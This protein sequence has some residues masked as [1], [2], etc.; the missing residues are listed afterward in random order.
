[1]TK[2]TAKIWEGIFGAIGGYAITC[3]LVGLWKLYG[4]TDIS[5]G[6]YLFVWASG[7]F[8][9][10]AFGLIVLFNWF[11]KLRELDPGGISFQTSLAIAWS[12]W[13]Y[14]HVG[15]RVMDS[16]LPLA[17]VA[18]IF[19]IQGRS[20]KRGTIHLTAFLLTYGGALLVM[21]ILNKPVHGANLAF[22]FLTA[23]GIHHFCWVQRRAKQK[24]RQQVQALVRAALPGPIAEKVLQGESITPEAYSMTLVSVDIAGFTK[25][26]EG[27]QPAVVFRTL[28]RLHARFDA[29]V[30]EN[31]GFRLKVNGD[32]YICFFGPW[33]TM[34]PAQCVAAAT[35]SFEAMN[36]ALKEV[37]EEGLFKGC[38]LRAGCAIGEVVG[39]QIG[40]MLAFDILG[41][42]VN[43]MA[44]VEAAGESGK[45]NATE[46][47]ASYLAGDERFRLEEPRKVSVK[48]FSQQVEMVFIRLVEES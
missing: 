33:S 48:G 28:N 35:I 8:C 5:D 21:D 46:T 19:S 15:Q 20:E 9:A 30:R 3:L 44:R 29:I 13:V 41:E 38:G 27:Q 47:V 1:M 12:L 36:K 34:T 6:E 24:Y 22:V 25:A 11:P 17:Y 26:T 31:G 18:S 16:V 45:F 39:G 23:L 43:L 32:G 4:L 10:C 14:T 37:D 2:N 42:K 7:M 40:E